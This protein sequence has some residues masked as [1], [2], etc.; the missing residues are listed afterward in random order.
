MENGIGITIRPVSSEVLVFEDNGQ[1]VFTKN[2]ITVD[3]PGGPAVA[4]SYE[5]VF[6]QFFSKYFTQSFLRSTGILDHLENPQPFKSNLNRG[7]RGGRSAGIAVGYK[8][9]SRRAL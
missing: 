2:P 3:N 8:W 7:K 5:R 6:D 9:I 1:K 4:G